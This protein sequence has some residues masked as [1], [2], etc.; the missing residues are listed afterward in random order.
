MVLKTQG[1]VAGARDQFNHCSAIPVK[2]TVWS[3]TE[4]V[5][6]DVVGTCKEEARQLS[7]AH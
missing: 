1:D 2:P 4:L 7:A 3:P 6:R 5:P